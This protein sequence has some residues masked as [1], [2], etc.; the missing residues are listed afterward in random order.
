MFHINVGSLNKNFDNLA[1]L[2]KCTQKQAD[3]AAVT[4]T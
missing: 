4:Q 2:L 3:D 1:Y